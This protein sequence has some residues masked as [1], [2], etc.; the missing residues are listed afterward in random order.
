LYSLPS[1]SGPH[2]IA[3]DAAGQLLVTLEFSGKIAKIDDNGNIV[4]E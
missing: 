4:A 3:F 2:G 1:G